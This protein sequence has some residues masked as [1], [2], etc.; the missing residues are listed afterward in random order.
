MMNASIRRHLLAGSVVSFGLFGGLVAWA[1]VAE[2]SGAVIATGVIAVESNL[3]K[4]QHPTG[5]VVG[6]L[7]VR[8]GSAHRL[9]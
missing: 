4:V 2:L 7:A 3:K 8:D 1:S 6:M 5:G 9:P